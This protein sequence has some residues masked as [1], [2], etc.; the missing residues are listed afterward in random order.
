MLR[1]LLMVLAAVV[2]PAGAGEWTQWGGPS[3][4]F[5]IAAPPAISTSWP[6]SGPPRLWHRALGDGYSSIVA[7][8]NTLYTMYRRGSQDV[9]IALDAASGKTV[10]EVP[11]DA[12]HEPN[13]NMMGG[14]GPFTTPLVVGDRL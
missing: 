1:L 5:R 10:W 12:K 13:A 6:S 3:R 2:P 14:P 11:V 9:V 7:A 8:D 4:D